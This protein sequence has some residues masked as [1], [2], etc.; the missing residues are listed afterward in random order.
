MNID[1]LLDT[2]KNF[3]DQIDRTKYKFKVP[4]KSDLISFA[5]IILEN[6]EFQF[7]GTLY[8]QVIGAPQGGILSPTATDLHLSTILTKILDRFQFKN[9]ISMICQYRDDGFMITE[10]NKSQIDEFFAIA[11]NIDPLL[12]FTYNF[13]NTE[14]TYLDTEVK[15]SL[16]IRHLSVNQVLN[17]NDDDITLGGL[18]TWTTTPSYL[19]KQPV[20][21]TP[22]PN[23]SKKI[24]ISFKQIK[25]IRGKYK[26]PFFLK[27][28]QTQIIENVMK[29]N[30]SVG[31]LPTGYGKSICFQILPILHEE[32]FGQKK[33]A[34]VFSPLKSLMYDQCAA[35]T[36]QGISS[37]C[38]V[39]RTDMSDETIEGLP[40]DDVN[41]HDEHHTEEITEDHK[42]TEG[43]TGP[44]TEDPA[45]P[46]TEDPTRNEIDILH[47]SNY[48]L[49]FITSKFQSL[50][51][52]YDFLNFLP[53]LTDDVFY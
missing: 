12:K 11:N 53:K 23:M 20:T 52:C 1:N 19:I 45:G 3:L 14:V 44:E 34:L 25:K 50:T 2:T 15:S 4:N 41:E 48:T 17:D 7:N 26:F 37:I 40:K 13:S 6:N 29:G 22:S 46:E 33:I 32:V 18:S 35:T 30:H 9:S 39:Q 28:K 24:R 21:S 47:I 16:M 49:D 8:K 51:S 43:P 42:E 38:I 31:I 36:S 10:C 5:K 27:E